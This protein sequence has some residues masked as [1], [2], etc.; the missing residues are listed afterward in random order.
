[1]GK[2]LP[3]PIPVRMT[4]SDWRRTELSQQKKKPNTSQDKR[5]LPKNCIVRLA[6]SFSAIFHEGVYCG[7]KRESLKIRFKIQIYLLSR[8]AH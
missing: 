7:P 6:G 2:H 4:L 8:G 1:M 3:N 5:E